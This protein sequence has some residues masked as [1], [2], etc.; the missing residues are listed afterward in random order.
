MDVLHSAF[1]V[2]PHGEYLSVCTHVHL[3]IIL[4]YHKRQFALLEIQA[5]DLGPA[6]VKKRTNQTHKKE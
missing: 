3:V 5:S 2:L 6:T 1:C 4:H